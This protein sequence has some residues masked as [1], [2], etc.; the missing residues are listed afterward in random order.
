MN[1]FATTLR[2]IRIEHGLRQ[3]DLASRIG[4]EKSYISALEIGLKGV[5]K[6]RFLQRVV[7]ALPLTEA[8]ASELAAA[9]S[10][11][12]RK[13][14]LELSAPAE[15]YLLL[16]DLRE[17][18]PRLTPAQVAAI[19]SILAFRKEAGTQFTTPGATTKSRA[20][21]KVAGPSS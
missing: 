11:A 18:L 16:Q 13:L 19:R 21:F 15:H 2:R 8:E 6:E 10:A 14:L 12:E 9:A 17:E 5:P 20:K 4:C 1:P 7:G 3:A